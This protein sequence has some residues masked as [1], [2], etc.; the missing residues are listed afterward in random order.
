MSFVNFVMNI[1]IIVIRIFMY[2]LV[3]KIMVITACVFVCIH[4][5]FVM[6][7]GFVD[8]SISYDNNNANK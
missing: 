1:I 6:K 5:L 4:L 3:A 2:F 8:L 7:F